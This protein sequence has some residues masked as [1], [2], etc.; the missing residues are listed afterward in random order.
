[1]DRQIK[2]NTS[3]I[4]EI[5]KDDQE[6]IVG[7]RK[8]QLKALRKLKRKREDFMLTVDAKF[9]DTGKLAGA[10][11]FW[12]MAWGILNPEYERLSSAVS[13]NDRILSKMNGVKGDIDV[14]KAKEVSVTSL[15]GNPYRSGTAR[16][17]Y[18]C[19]IHGEKTASLI[20]YHETN[21]WHCFGCGAGSDSIDLVMKLNG[22][23][24]IDAVKYLNNG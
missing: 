10:R 22:Y 14:S 12:D 1:M 4:A 20:V 6:W 9:L 19:P 3:D 21:T 8:M 15:L 24:F 2:L 16:S 11:F 18:V 17:A 5:F 23:T 13:A 7:V